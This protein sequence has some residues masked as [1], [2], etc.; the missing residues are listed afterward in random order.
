M[1]NKSEKP[2][3]IAD[4]KINHI[5]E[6][7]TI[8]IKYGIFGILW[9]V[10]TD[11]ALSFVANDSLVYMYLQ[12]IKG[13]VYVAITMVFIY[14]LIR[15]RMKIIQKTN[16]QIIEAYKKLKLTNEELMALE[17]ELQYQK[18][19]IQNIIDVAPVVICVWNEEGKI[20]NINPYGLNLFGYDQDEIN[21]KTLVELLAT[22][23]KSKAEKLL[24]EFI[25][26]NGRNYEVRFKTKSGEKI[27]LLWSTSS[28]NIEKNEFVSI[29]LDVT[30]SKKYE[31]DIKYLAFYDKLTGLPNKTLLELEVGNLISGESD[32]SFAISFAIAYI[33]IDNFKYINETFGHQV[34]DKFLKYIGE[35]FK[36][37]IESPNFAAR[38]SGDKFAIVISDFKS[39][40]EVA[41]YIE[42]IKNC[43]GKTWISDN[44]QFFIAMSVGIVFFPYDGKDINTLLKNAEIAM[45]T[46]KQRGK[47]QTVIYSKDLQKRSEWHINMAN[48]I[49]AGMDSQEFTL[50]YQPQFNLDTNEIVGAEA[51]IRWKHL[52][53]QFI[54]PEKFIPIAEIT[55]QIFKLELWI[56]E[57]ALKQKQ[58]WEAKGLGRISISINLSAKTLNS[59][60]NFEKLEELFDS[61]N[62]DYS[63]VCIEITETAIISNV[64]PLVDKLNRLKKRGIKIAL[65]DFG[66]GYSS[67]TYLKQLPIDI[68]KLDR[69]FIKLISDCER[70]SLIV[71][72]IL[73]L[74]KDLKYKV[75]AEG[76]ESQEQLECLKNYGCENGQGFLLSKPLP[77]D[78]V[79]ELLLQTISKTEKQ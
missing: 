20:V 13:W 63:K 58:E 69:D 40:D 18:N 60:E 35:V 21:N 10:F 79:T 5:N 70:T 43:L 12:T 4:N 30:E 9:I 66:T 76:I 48:K 51:L 41:Q 42:S 29:G 65:D 72:S 56:F 73:N 24:K 52:N 1:K 67:L 7:L 74:A 53:E 59:I 46:A 33:D 14:I 38:V 6:A 68:I 31:E 47:N 26:S 27:F 39:S 78:K 55:G 54:S 15:N 36:S 49:Q 71:K 2:K 75:V 17:K 22:K 28:L 57:T 45:Y 44:Y 23:E 77:H 19:L 50:F 62:I 64:V 25:K 32:I 34:G 37:K 11:V 3:G 8:A 16:N 61:Y